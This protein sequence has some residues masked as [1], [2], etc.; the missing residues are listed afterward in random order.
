MIYV[1]DVNHIEKTIYF[2]LEKNTELKLNIVQFGN[3]IFYKFIFKKDTTKREKRTIE[4]T[5]KDEAIRYFLEIQVCLFNKIYFE[6]I[7]DN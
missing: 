4:F 1:H 3:C 7:N 2:I 5:K 6:T